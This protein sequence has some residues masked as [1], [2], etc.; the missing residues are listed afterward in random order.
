[1]II[2]IAD[3]LLL[4][5]ELETLNRLRPDAEHDCVRVGGA[6]GQADF[7]GEGALAAGE[8]ADA[9]GPVISGKPPL[10]EDQMQVGQ[11]LITKAAR[12]IDLTERQQAAHRILDDLEVDPA[13][14]V[15]D[16]P[17]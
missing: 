17:W 10:A 14:D 5:Q 7:V 3:H 8:R 2:T 16:Q 1:L 4:A 6:S 9:Q 11:Q 12:T 15:H 13:T